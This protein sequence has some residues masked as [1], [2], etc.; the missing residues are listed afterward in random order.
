MT[1]VR[2]LAVA[3]MKALFLVA[4]LLA[5]FWGAQAGYP[6]PTNVTQV[7]GYIEVRHV[8]IFWDWWGHHTLDVPTQALE[9]LCE[10]FS[11][12]LAQALI[13]VHLAMIKMVP[14]TMRWLYRRA[15]GSL[16]S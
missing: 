11:A 6:W 12:P 16:S 15:A 14:P 5:L 2:D 8:D 13:R 9:I 1:A 10:A 3:E 4:G 7:H